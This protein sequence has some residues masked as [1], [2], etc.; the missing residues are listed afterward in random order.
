MPNK[1][2]NIKKILQNP[3]TIASEER[4]MI[5]TIIGSMGEVPPFVKKRRGCNIR[6]KLKSGFSGMLA[7]LLVLSLLLVSGVTTAA[8]ANDA[9]ALIQSGAAVVE[10]K[11]GEPSADGLFTVTLSAYNA[12]FNT[13]QYVFRYDATQVQPVDA[14]GAEATR[15]RGFGT[16]NE[17]CSDWLNQITGKLETD[18]KL[19]QVA[20]Y[21]DVGTGVYTVGTEGIVLYEFNFKR[22]GTGAPGFTLATSADG[23]AYEKSFSQGG[24]LLG[25]TKFDTQLVISY[26]DSWGQDATTPVIPPMPSNPTTPTTPTIPAPITPPVSTDPN[27][28]TQAQIDA[29]LQ[30]TIFLRT[31][32][33]AAAVSGGLKAIDS[34]NKS[35][36]P[37]QNSDGRTM[38]P[39]RFIAESMG[40]KVG[41]DGKTQTV[42]IEMDGTIIQMTI[43]HKTYTI[44]GESRTMDTAPVLVKGWDRTVVP[45]RFV[46][47]ALGMDVQWNA[48][49]RIVIIAPGTDPWDA[50]DPIEVATYSAA[51]ELMD[52][53]LYR[54]FI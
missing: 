54:M 13:L 42:T 27:T 17:D 20:A 30:G 7:L 8:G 14:S 39:V 4:K 11:A 40:A 48:Q 26:A 36:V 19:F 44:N 5:P 53:T 18:V 24:A 6:R 2:K 21:V 38:I 35:V 49:D 1:G 46:A 34:A 15:F 45:I 10:L 33:F 16:M 47:E 3:L 25:K 28:V 51:K 9:S 23:G 29:R 52:N 12:S 50:A 32:D 22:T 31:G 37:Q 43:G 41:W